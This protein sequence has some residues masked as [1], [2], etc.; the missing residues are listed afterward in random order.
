M[1][2]EE[3]ERDGCAGFTG[4]RP[5]DEFAAALKAIA[6]AYDERF[7]RKPTVTEVL[8]NLE[9]LLGSVPERYV[10]D[11]QGLVGCKISINR[12]EAQRMKPVDP[13]RFEGVY[14]EGPPEEYQVVRRDAQGRSTDDVVIAVPTLETRD[15]TLV[16]EYRR[17]SPDL[18]ESTAEQLIIQKLLREFL[19]DS[20]SDEADTIAFR[21]LDSGARRSLPYPK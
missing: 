10:S 4:D 5:L 13:A 17:L 11:P 19:I 2:W 6:R 16:A 15:R 14:A 20:Y 21:D 18:D 9:R 8:F 7:G 3:F 12:R 1:A